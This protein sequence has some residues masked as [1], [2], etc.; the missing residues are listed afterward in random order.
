MQVTRLTASIR[1]EIYAHIEGLYNPK[2]TTLLAQIQDPSV[3]E[4][5]WGIL[6]P[7]ELRAKLNEVEHWV[8][9]NRTQYVVYAARTYCIQLTQPRY[10][11]LRHLHIRSD[12]AEHTKFKTL[13]DAHIALTAELNEVKNA[14]KGY[15]F[16]KCTNMAQ[17]IRVWPSVLDYVSGGTR[18]IIQR[19]SEANTKTRRK[20][21]PKE[22]V[23][24]DEIKSILIRL[25]ILNGS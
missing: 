12:Q 19:N 24:P 1:Y 3:G 10:Q 14:I 16:D 17:V 2:L 15:V 18:E 8:G 20:K 21:P 13:A 4:E 7:P 6:V 5:I 11:C 9:K 25:R 22:A 23:I